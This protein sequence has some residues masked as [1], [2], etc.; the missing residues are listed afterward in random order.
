MQGEGDDG[1]IERR[2][3]GEKGHGSPHT[4]TRGVSKIGGALCPTFV[5]QYDMYIHYMG[6]GMQE[7]VASA[8]TAHELV[9]RKARKDRWK[10]L[11]RQACHTVCCQTVYKEQFSYH[12]VQVNRL[13]RCT[14][15]IRCLQTPK[16]FEK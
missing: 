16:S 7:G 6:R 3:K 11:A 8:C 4:I 15:S 13:R 12:Q 2:G 5:F 1:K 14:N 10:I 9:H